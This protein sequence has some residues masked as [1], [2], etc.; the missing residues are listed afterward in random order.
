MN[1]QLL[2]GLGVVIVIIAGIFAYKSF[3]RNAKAKEEAKEFLIGLEDQLFKIF[4]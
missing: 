2:L 3:S 1:E 4:T